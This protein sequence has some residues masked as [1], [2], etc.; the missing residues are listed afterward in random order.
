MSSREAVGRGDSN[1]IK[2]AGCNFPILGSFLYWFLFYAGFFL[3][4]VSSPYRFLFLKQILPP[5]HNNTSKAAPLSLRA[6]SYLVVR[7]EVLISF[8]IYKGGIS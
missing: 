2:I 8:I 5:R 1:E 6:E 3:I 4:L 7:E